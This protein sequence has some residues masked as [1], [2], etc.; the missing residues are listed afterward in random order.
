MTL[1]NQLSLNPLTSESWPLGV[2][3]RSLAVLAEVILVHQQAERA[4]LPEDVPG[5]SEE[6]IINVW[7]K[8]LNK[9][10][11]VAMQQA[12][13]TTFDLLEGKN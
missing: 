8:C 1:L 11:L 2:G 9:L 4:D 12:P 6:L 3:P 10:Q 13:F 7:L 5:V